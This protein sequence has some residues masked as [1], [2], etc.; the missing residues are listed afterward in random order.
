VLEAELDKPD[1]GD[2]TTVKRA[3]TV[4]AWSG[5][6]SVT[7]VLGKAFFTEKNPYRL[8]T[9]RACVVAAQIDMSPLAETIVRQVPTREREALYRAS[10]PKINEDTRVFH[11]MRHFLFTVAAFETDAACAML[12]DQSVLSPDNLK[13]WQLYRTGLG[14]NYGYGI[15]MRKRLAARFKDTGGKEGRYFSELAG[16][17]GSPALPTLKERRWLTWDTE[18]D[19]D[20][21]AH[22]IQF[23]LDFGIKESEVAGLLRKVAEQ[24]PEADRA[25]WIKVIKWSGADIAER[26][27]A[28][29]PNPPAAPKKK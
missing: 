3:L 29:P 17:V 9:F 24:A 7:H 16:Q 13:N 25:E 26:E 5:D 14:W 8:Q 27:A 1:G 10:V 18:T 6:L 11:R 15:G 22:R 12:I 4:L 2:S 21:K 20:R 19:F 23:A 28:L